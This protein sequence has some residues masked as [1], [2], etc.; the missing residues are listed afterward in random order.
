MMTETSTN[1]RSAPRL[2]AEGPT[3]P[4][5][6]RR[7][8]QTPS[9]L[10]QTE[11]L[12]LVAE[13]DVPVLLTGETGTGKTHL[14]RLLHD[15]SPRRNEP[16]VTVACG[17]LPPQLVESEFFGHVRG[18]FTGADRDRPG[19]IAAAGRGTLL[20]D[21]IDT[22]GLE[23][24]AKLLRVLDSGEYEPVGG[25]ETLHRACRI[26]V[27]S[28]VDLAELVSW[29]EF[30]SDLFYRLHVMPFHLPPLR[31]RVQDIAPLARSLAAR[32]GS[33]FDKELL[34]ISPEALSV[35]EEY[36]WPGNLRELDNVMRQA[37]LLSHGTVLLPRHLPEWVRKPVIIPMPFAVSSG[38]S[39]RSNRESVER[40]MIR[41][42]LADH[43]RSRARAAEE[44]GISRVTLYKKMKKYGLART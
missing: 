22:L 31:E 40:G 26:V 11:L 38:T 33:Q 7:L 20:L 43:G 44:L 24:Q 4:E 39:L 25:N 2:G 21:E 12:A 41:R 30:R 1:N 27:A 28:N 37:V 3:I 34:D 10:P 32:F 23:Q 6:Q 14:A 19:K 9:L 36:P 8:A 35:L 18:A 5:I 15:C 42:A 17:A 13:H 29:G 16:F